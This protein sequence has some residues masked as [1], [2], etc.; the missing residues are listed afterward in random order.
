MHTHLDICTDFY[1]NYI[2]YLYH[3]FHVFLLMVSSISFSVPYLFSE[4]SDL[5]R[6]I[7][8]NLVKLKRSTLQGMNYLLLSHLSLFVFVEC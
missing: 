1:C 2:T 6:K 7:F 5:R 4:F 3:F 8:N